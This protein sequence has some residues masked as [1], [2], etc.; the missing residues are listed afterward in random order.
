MSGCDSGGVVVGASSVVG[1]SAGTG[2]KIF[3]NGIVNSGFF[4]RK[5][6]DVV[7]IYNGKADKTSIP[8]TNPGKPRNSAWINV[9]Q[10]DAENISK[11]NSQRKIAHTTK[12]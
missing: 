11:L 7:A 2:V 4:V 6:M 5:M 3:G 9:C 1:L 12:I 10:F 8:N